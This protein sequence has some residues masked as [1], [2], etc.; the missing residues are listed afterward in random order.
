[1]IRRAIGVLV[2]GLAVVSPVAC[3][4]DGPFKAGQTWG[5]KYICA[6]GPTDL[7]LKIVSV[8]KGNIESLFDFVHVDSGNKGVFKLSG[9]YKPKTRSLDLEPVDWI[10]PHPPGWEM[11][12]MS[13]AVSPDGRNFT[14]T[15]THPNCTSF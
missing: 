5:G 13:G 11:V 7:T 1:M 4:S 2:V 9:R 12:G 6:Q 10:G 8:K 3:R 14:G 15:I